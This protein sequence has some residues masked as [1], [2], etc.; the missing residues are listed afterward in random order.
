MPELNAPNAAA[1]AVGEPSAP[2]HN[3]QVAGAPAEIADELGAEDGDASE[4]PTFVL[5]E[6]P[7]LILN[8]PPAKRG[9]SHAADFRPAEQAP[10]ASQ[11]AIRY[12]AARPWLIVFALV[13]CVFILA[14]VSR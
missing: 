2:S 11:V 9:A 5:P 10:R 1:E 14:L 8:S 4:Q 3:V 12:L 7:T 6:Q 13:L